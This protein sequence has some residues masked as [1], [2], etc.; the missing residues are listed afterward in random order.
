MYTDRSS[1]PL[2]FHKF[3]KYFSL[4]ASIILS[5]CGFIA[6]IDYESWV[7]IIAMLC[8]IALQTGAFIGFLKWRDYGITCFL[9]SIIISGIVCLVLFAYGEVPFSTF[10]ATCVYLVVIVIYYNKRSDLFARKGE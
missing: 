4:P 7:G 8:L 5:I 1:A 10:I 2:A 9:L 3:T 6:C